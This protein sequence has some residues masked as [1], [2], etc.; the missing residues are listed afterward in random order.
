MAKVQNLF[1]NGRM[2]SDTDYSVVDNKSYVRAEN[3][4]I[5]GEGNDG[6]F[7]NLKGSELVSSEFTVDGMQVVGIGEGNDNNLFYFLAHKNGLSKIVK[8]NTETK[9]SELIIQ[10]NTVLRFDLVRWNNGVE[11]F[12]YKYIL[13]ID[14]IG[15]M[16]HFSNENWKYPRVINLKRISDYANGFTEK[17]ISLIKEPP[18]LAPIV[19][20]KTASSG[21]EFSEKQNKFISF[22]YRYKYSD[23]SFSPLSFY[24]ESVF[25]TQDNIDIDDK[26][27]N[28]GMTNK[29]DN[30][31]LSVNSGNKNVTD[32]EVY[33]REHGSNTAYLIYSANKEKLGILDNANIDNIKYNYSTNYTVLNDKD[34]NLLYSNVPNYPKTQTA[35]G[36]RLVY[37]NYKEG[38]ELLDKDGNDV[39]IDFEITKNKNPYISGE[40]NKTIISLIKNKL[41]VIYYDDYNVSSTALLPI[42]Q[43]DA[44]FEFDYDDRLTVNSLSV[45]LLNNAPK[46]ATKMKFVVKTEPLNFEVVHSTIIKKVANKLYILLDANNRD[47]IKKGDYIFPISDG[48][49]YKEY[50]VEEAK[51]FNTSEGFVTEEGF[52]AII[53]LDEDF[54]IIK[55]TGYDI[56]VGTWV[57]R[58]V[59]IPN[60]ILN[61]SE[62]LKTYTLAFPLDYQ[63]TID[64]QDFINNEGHRMIIVY[65]DYSQI[66]KG[67]YFTFFAKFTYGDFSSSD[68]SSGVNSTFKRFTFIDDVVIRKEYFADKDYNNIGELLLDKFDDYRFD[69]EEKTDITTGKKYLEFNTNSFY[70]EYLRD[71][72]PS[73]LGTKLDSWNLAV[74]KTSY[75]DLKRGYVP[76][77]FRTINKENLN[78][79]YYETPK[80]YIIN[81]G[82]YL[83]DR[84]DVDGKPIFDIEYYNG[85]SWGTGVESYKI[86][87]E[88]NQKELNYNFRGTLYEPNG[89]KQIHRKNDIT[90]GGLYNYELGINN[91]GIFN[92]SEVNWKTLP[93]HYGEIQRIISTKG[94]I[95]VYFTNATG[96]VTYG[97]SIIMDL[98]ANESV[99][100]SN[101]VLGDFIDVS[102][103]GVCDNPESVVNTPLGNYFTDTKRRRVLIHNGR[104]V[105]E[106]N[107]VQSGFHKEGV[108]LLK[109]YKSFL[110]AYDESHGEY[111]IGLDN[112]KSVAFNLGQKGFVSYFTNSFDYI[113]GAN[114]NLYT[115]YKG[116]L[117]QNEVT[118]KMNDLVG[119]GLF[120]SS[121]KFVVNP[122]M[123][124][125]KIFK[126][127][128][129]QSNKP[130][131]TY[132]KTNY[133]ESFIPAKNY[134]LKESFYSSAILRNTKGNRKSYGV[135]KVESI[136]GNVLKFSYPISNSISCGD[137]LMVKDKS[138]EYEITNINGKELT[139][140]SV[141]QI[142]IGDICYGIKKYDGMFR[143][144][145]DPI[146]GKWM[147]VTL[148]SDT[149]EEIILNSITTEVV[150]SK[151]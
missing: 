25:E 53:K 57:K 23:G 55:N 11:I 126:A 35:V 94:D 62:T 140:S 47:K 105:Q 114:G 31:V 99:G 113:K 7:K 45:K 8:Y 2:D 73:F 97:K 109:T 127:I 104:E 4:R 22:T 21:I 61:F 96:I 86:K 106:L 111:V 81:N 85:F 121:V 129:L 63:G 120:S 44:D 98:T 107:P 134:E 56:K 13:N 58:N 79:F 51:V 122:Q 102:S 9:V 60:T 150:E 52:Y 130:F 74:R 149:N 133:T 12:P 77:N 26:R 10:D 138:L 14:Q 18:L 38:Y 75:I 145:G 69:F 78:E 103:Y 42:D 147:E 88:F 71:T 87:D 95:S 5:A 65:D 66:K 100:L 30:I 41:A 84:Y 36:N 119:Q 124:S 135:G 67:T 64:E 29:Y 112:K 118:K 92:A 151:L 49:N 40:N 48:S 27:S 32:I 34:T 39:L 82:N 93:S 101:E 28:K 117:Y 115:A 24:T 123:D 68:S 116:E 90:Y 19:T 132:I 128:E 43:T 59:Y 1:I 54:N 89:Y 6:A 80:T 141:S 131:D 37:G 17:D 3:M 125:D 70:A 46:W 76:I 108:E 16:L 143:P 110:G 137:S 20:S 148:K 50:Y 33:A 144:D 15:D 146:R 91:L 142:A 139:L 72:Y 83:A 136:V